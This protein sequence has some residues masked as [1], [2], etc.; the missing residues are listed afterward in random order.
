M[1]YILIVS[2]VLFL[3]TLGVTAAEAIVQRGKLTHTVFFKFKATAT[4]EQIATVEKDFRALKTKIPGIT[5]LEWGTNVSPE[6]HDKACRE[7]FLRR[8]ILSP[9][10]S[11][12]GI[13]LI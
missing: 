1:K 4:K 3:I 13:F 6:K 2:G 10:M 8:R 7:T 5:T 9:Q 11:P 12:Q